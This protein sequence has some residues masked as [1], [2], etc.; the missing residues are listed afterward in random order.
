MSRV[1]HTSSRCL[2]LSAKIVTDAAARAA[3]Q[4]PLALLG[5]ILATPVGPSTVAAAN[6]VARNMPLVVLLALIALLFQPSEPAANEEEVDVG[7]TNRSRWPAP[8]GFH[9]ETAA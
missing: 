2:K 8:N 5:A 6:V 7:G 1:T 9:H 3:A 4:T